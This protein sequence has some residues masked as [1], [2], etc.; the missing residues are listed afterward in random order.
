MNMNQMFPGKYLKAADLEGKAWT[1]TVEDVVM[2]EL[3]QGN[4]KEWK[5]V[6]RLVGSERGIVLNKTN[7]IKIAGLFQSEDTEAWKGQ[8]IKIVSEKVPFGSKLVDSIRVK[9]VDETVQAPPS[10]VNG[11]PG[12]SEDSTGD[13]PLPF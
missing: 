1:V 10:G 7:A 3:G 11:A 8:K 2:E 5:P 4:D 9:G 6:L 13:D 12:T